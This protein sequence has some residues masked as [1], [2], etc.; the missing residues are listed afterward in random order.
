MSTLYLH[1][2]YRVQRQANGI[3]CVTLVKPRRRDMPAPVTKFCAVES[4]LSNGSFSSLVNGSI[5][6]LL[7]RAHTWF[8]EKVR[9]ILGLSMVATD[10]C[11]N[12]Q[13]NEKLWV[14]PNLIMSRVEHVPTFFFDP[15][16]DRTQPE[17]NNGLTQL[18]PKVMGQ[19]RANNF[20][21]WTRKDP[22][23]TRLGSSMGQHFSPK[24]K[25][26]QPD[27]KTMVNPTRPNPTQ[28]NDVMGRAR[29]NNFSHKPKRT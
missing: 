19:A 23:Q 12:D 11:W 10:I 28:P 5:K 18:N 3:L 29:A 9:Q 4:D 20:W 24:T 17:E 7:L 21:P 1:S 14:N 2:D 16:P 15:K 8:I 26:I 6:R 13:P 27:E 22:T 25:R